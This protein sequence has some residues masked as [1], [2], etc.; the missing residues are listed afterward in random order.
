MKNMSRNITLLCPICGNSQFESLDE[1]NEE[2]GDASDQARYKCSD[3]GSIFT[4]EQLMEENSEK[5]NIAIDEMKDDVL[6][7]FEKELKKALKKWGK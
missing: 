3:C 4:K 6:N 2:F 7:E 5:I 1:K